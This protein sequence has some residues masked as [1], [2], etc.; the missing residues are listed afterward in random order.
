MKLS[1]LEFL[2]FLSVCVQCNFRSDPEFINV[3]TD[4]EEFTAVCEQ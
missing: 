4:E 3:D 2:V 1:S